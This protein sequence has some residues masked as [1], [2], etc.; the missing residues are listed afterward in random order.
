MQTYFESEKPSYELFGLIYK[1]YKMTEEQ[2]LTYAQKRYLSDDYRD[3]QKQRSRENYDKI[4]TTK[5]T[6]IETDEIIKA[7]IPKIDELVEKKVMFHIR[8]NEN[9]MQYMFQ[10]IQSCFRELT[11]SNIVENNMI[12]EYIHHSDL[13]EK[14]QHEY[15]NYFINIQEQYY[16]KKNGP[17][18]QTNEFLLDPYLIQ[19]INELDATH[20]VKLLYFSAIHKIMKLLNMDDEMI[21]QYET[22]MNKNNIILKKERNKNLGNENDFEWEILLQA[23]MEKRETL[24]DIEKLLSCLYIERPPLRSEY[25]RNV[26]ITDNE[27]KYSTGNILIWKDDKLILVLRDFKNVKKFGEYRYEFIGY[28][29]EII[30]K[31]IEKIGMDGIFMKFTPNTL[32]IKLRGLIEKLI[33]KKNSGLQY[34]RRSYETYLQN[35][36]NYI[37]T[38]IEERINMHR[39]VL[40]SYMIAQTYRVVKNE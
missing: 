27:T 26:I 34:I 6:G 5:I 15:I 19:F 40:H 23:Y 14:T 7:L 4:Q 9:Q 38:S 28:A 2:L 10:K 8:R 1:Q 31:H 17:I 33:G 36:D 21:E 35:Q 20:G 29:K 16:N 3:K 37:K 18:I 25:T 13:S 24:T 30:L 22:E 12:L 32:Q 39:D 11:K